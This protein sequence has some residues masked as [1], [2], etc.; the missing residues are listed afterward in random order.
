MKNRLLLNQTPAWALRLIYA[1]QSFAK[2]PFPRQLADKNNSLSCQPLFIISPGRSGTTLLRSMLVA[3]GEIAIPP[4]SFVIGPTILKYVSF[5]ST[6]NDIVRLV[7]AQFESHQKF[8]RWETDLRLAYRAGINIPYSDRSLAR[9]IDEIF[10]CYL[11]Q[12]LP[13][14]LYWGDKSPMNTFYLTW[15]SK[16]FP[17]ARYIHMLRDGRDVVAS[18]VEQG[19]EVQSAVQR[20]NHGTRECLKLSKEIGSDRFLEIRYEELVSEPV[21]TLIRV[22]SFLGLRYKSRMLDYWKLPTT[23]EH[24]YEHHHQNLKKPISTKSV[25]RWSERLNAQQREYVEGH[26]NALL[27]LLG[28]L[29]QE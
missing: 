27:A 26:T 15:I 17:K 1:V 29:Q 8:Y 19:Q 16:T 4:E 13:D 11:R 24:R 12:Q 20:W 28:Y 9:L 2:V 6:W 23:V 18:A 10:R 22:C 5:N 7:V 3:G 14:A 21:D 25:G